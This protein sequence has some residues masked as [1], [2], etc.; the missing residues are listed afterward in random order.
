MT[1]SGPS[2]HISSIDN[3]YLWRIYVSEKHARQSDRAF[4]VGDG[5]CKTHDMRMCVG[6]CGTNLYELVLVLLEN[7]T[8]NEVNISDS[9]YTTYNIHSTTA[10]RQVNE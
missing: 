5:G 4:R 6:V 9:A 8:K 7:T 1:P 2:A 3:I 10:Q